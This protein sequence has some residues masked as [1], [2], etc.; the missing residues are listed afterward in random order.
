MTRTAVAGAL[1]ALVLPGP[2]CSAPSRSAPAPTHGALDGVVAQVGP[3]TIPG[4]LVASVAG[5]KGIQPRA[6]L[7]DLIADALV[8]QGGSVAGLER[9]P[10]VSWATSSALARGVS[11]RLWSQARDAGPPTDD[12]LAEVTVVHAVVLRT[13]IT[14]ESR[15]IAIA[16]SIADAERGAPTVDEFLAR[17]RATSPREVRMTAERLPPFG[18]DGS[19][20]PDFIVAAFGL[21]TPGETSGVVESSFGWH[22]IRLVARGLPAGVELEARRSGLAGAVGLVRARG[23]LTKLLGARKA[24]T[25]IEILP[26]SESWM[27][28]AIAPR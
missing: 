11:A 9:A 4:A 20:D 17:A 1:V 24:A 12:E 16:Q 14:P 28:Q 23:R 2:A 27:A 18:V 7:D 10:D 19:I 22:V 6:A 25:H 8:A 26:S 13:R 3:V 15:A 5:A 21:H